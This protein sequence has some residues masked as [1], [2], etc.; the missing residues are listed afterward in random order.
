MDS[1]T[2]AYKRDLVERLDAECVAAEAE[3]VPC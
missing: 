2:Y 3:G 1:K